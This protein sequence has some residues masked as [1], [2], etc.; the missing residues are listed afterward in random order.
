MA[1]SIGAFTD[2]FLMVLKLSPWLSTTEQKVS[3]VEASMVI[4]D[5]VNF[6][7]RSIFSRTSS[8]LHHNFE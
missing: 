4:L 3:M 2:E 8:S 7:L 5:P 1:K 6:C